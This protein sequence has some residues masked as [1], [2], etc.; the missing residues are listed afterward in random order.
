MNYNG[1]VYR[2]PL[3]ANTFLLP[4]TEGCTHNSCKFCNMY[5]DTSFR[6][7]KMS[8]IEQYL[9]EVNQQYESYLKHAD[10]VYLIGAAPFALSAKYLLER[11]EL[12]KKYMPKVSVI[13]MYARIDNI[14]H[15]TDEELAELK[16]AGVDELY[17]GIESGLD[18][19]LSHMNKGFSVKQILEQCERL[20]RAGIRHCDLLMLGTAGKN[21]WQV[22]GIAAAKLENEIKPYKILVT[23]MSA[24]EGTELNDEILNGDFELA[25][26][27]EMLQEEYE[28][29]QDLE[30]SDT[31]FWAMHTLDAVGI[32]GDLKNDKTAMLS[33]LQRAMDRIQDGAYTRQGREHFDAFCKRN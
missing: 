9:S 8:E 11:I 20:N 31:Y 32:S 33:K 25:S 2:P 7:W 24:F 3:E 14:A 19:V 29:L 27:K 18:S 30:L 6:M 1:T 5:K 26:G 12:I 28:L 10:R 16:A 22:A 4:I 17:I 13:T 23:S 21:Q 15:K